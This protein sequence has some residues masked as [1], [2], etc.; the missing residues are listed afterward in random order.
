MSSKRLEPHHLAWL[1]KHPERSS[2]WLRARL[3]DGFHV[4]HIDGNPANND[5]DNLVLIDGVDH[6]R[7]H[8]RLYE[9]PRVRGA[10]RKVR[11]PVKDED[12][13]RRARLAE[14]RARL[15]RRGQWG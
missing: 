4:H 12:D 14:G 6:L 9:P 15:A 5:R 1:M 7:I 13:A 8:N 11:A 2:D 10:R 3:A